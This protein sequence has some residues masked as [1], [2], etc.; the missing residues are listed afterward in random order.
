M[1]RAIKTLVPHFT[2]VSPSLNKNSQLKELYFAAHTVIYLLDGKVNS[3]GRTGSLLW[4]FRFRLQDE[5][6][7]PQTSIQ[8]LLSM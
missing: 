3:L 4:H 8:E 2:L 1:S 6:W 5:S 7:Y